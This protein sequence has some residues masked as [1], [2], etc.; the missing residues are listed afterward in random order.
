M[1]VGNLIFNEGDN[2]NDEECKGEYRGKDFLVQLPETKE[3]ITLADGT[4]I[5]AK[6]N[7]I[8]SEE[9]KKRYM[10]RRDEVFF[11]RIFT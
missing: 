11:L 3:I 1:F 5:D 2:D 7:E 6:H 8:Q 9:Q 4:V 10:E